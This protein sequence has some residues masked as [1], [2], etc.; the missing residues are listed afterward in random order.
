[1]ETNALTKCFREC[2]DWSANRLAGD[3]VSHL[4]ENWETWLS[5]DSEA[6]RT[7]KQL[8][9]AAEK[10]LAAQIAFIRWLGMQPEFAGEKS[11]L[12]LFQLAQ[13][14]EYKRWLELERYQTLS[15]DFK[16]GG[17]N[18]L[19]VREDRAGTRGEVKGLIAVAVPHT[20][21]SN[22]HQQL[23]SQ[24]S[25]DRVMPIN[26]RAEND[27]KLVLE[28][29]GEAASDFLRWRGLGNV[30]IYLVGGDLILL[31]LPRCLRTLLYW[32]QWRR[33]V[34]A[35]DF[36]L[37]IDHPTGSEVTGPSLGLA[38]AL[39]IVTTVVR[40]FVGNHAITSSAP[41]LLPSRLSRCGV[42][43]TIGNTGRVSYV[44]GIYEKVRAI[45]LHPGI[46][47]GVI[48]QEN[49]PDCPAPSSVEILGAKSLSQVLRRLIPIRKTWVTVNLLLLSLPFIIGMGP[50][51]RMIDRYFISPPV[52]K[53]IKTSWGTFSASYIKTQGCELRELDRVSILL[54]HARNDG[55]TRVVV[56]A[57]RDNNTGFRRQCLKNPNEVDDWHPEVMLIVRD[58]KAVFDYQADPKMTNPREALTVVIWRDD[59]AEELFGLPLY[60][61]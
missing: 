3:P 38:A 54:E 1:M 42:T 7:A 50:G 5:Y 45:E 48:P 6:A 60:I 21:T 11:I 49:L 19:F 33:R 39:A 32:W 44:D 27:S 31:T 53:S 35:N 17:I 18:G 37:L 61:R 4:A 23:S 52:M 24:P 56:T 59:R 43:G 15:S 12:A 30:L 47:L 55:L 40:P 2:L 28:Q 36:Y 13:C 20:A 58:S 8:C 10:E 26:F 14:P 46:E 41:I 29:A 9:Q 51:W 25:R 22:R 16:Q 34:Q 57:P